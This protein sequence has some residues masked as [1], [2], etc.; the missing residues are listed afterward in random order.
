MEIPPYLLRPP[1]FYTL[2]EPWGKEVWRWIIK[3]A[4]ILEETK[5]LR[6]KL[7]KDLEKKKN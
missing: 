3:N 2:D 7:L 4:K 1:R 6:E 5:G